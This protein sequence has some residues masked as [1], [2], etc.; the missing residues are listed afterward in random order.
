MVY[1]TGNVGVFQFIFSLHALILIRLIAS[2]IRLSAYLECLP[3]RVI[4]YNVVV[5]VPEDV[6]WRLRGVGDQAGQVDHRPAV[7]VQVWRPLDP[8]VR[9]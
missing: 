6:G 3:W 5:L 9:N 2:P 8:H 4:G 7:N 1:D